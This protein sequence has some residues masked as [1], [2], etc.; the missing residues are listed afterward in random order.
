MANDP[1]LRF[2]RTEY[3]QKIHQLLVQKVESKLSTSHDSDSRS[4]GGGGSGSRGV[5]GG[6]RGGGG[7]TQGGGSRGGSRGGSSR[8]GIRST[9][10]PKNQIG[11][12]VQ[13]ECRDRSRMP[14][15]A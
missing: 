3:Y 12:A 4:K 10:T 7:G 11:R 5:G 15:S 2:Q 13:Q 14:S 9:D 6:S 8:S 1:F